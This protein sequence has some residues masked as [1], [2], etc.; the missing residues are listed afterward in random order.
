MSHAYPPV[1]EPGTVLYWSFDHNNMYDVRFGIRTLARL[2]KTELSQEYPF[3]RINKWRWETFNLT[4]SYR[5][6]FVETFDMAR[7]AAERVLL[8]HGF[9]ILTDREKNLL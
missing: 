9:R 5:Y 8:E 1:P 3:L 7:I 2:T 6:G 4:V